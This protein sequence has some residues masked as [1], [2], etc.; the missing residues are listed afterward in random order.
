MAKE[1]EPVRTFGRPSSH[2]FMYPFKRCGIGVHLSLFLFRSFSEKIKELQ[3]LVSFTFQQKGG[4]HLDSDRKE[5]ALCAV[6]ALSHFNYPNIP[7]RL[8]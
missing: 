5:S 3:S 7:A 2:F 6:F 4:V 8:E 1:S